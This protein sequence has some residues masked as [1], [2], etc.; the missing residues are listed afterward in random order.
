MK[1]VSLITTL[2]LASSIAIYAQ[3]SN[4]KEAKSIISSTN[5]D[6]NKAQTL[7]SAALNDPATKN[8]AETWNIAGKIQKRINETENEKMFLKKPCDTLAFYNSILE[9]YKYF[10]KCDE[11]AQIPNEKNKVKNKFRKDNAATM[12][13]NRGNIINGGVWNYRAKK[14]PEALIFFGTYIES[15]S[16][17]M[18]AE[19][20]I[21]KKDTLLGQVAYNAV[22]IAEMIGDHSSVIKY[23]PIAMTDKANGGNALRLL[24]ETYKSEK[25]SIKYIEAIKEGV[26]KY[27]DNQFFILNMIDYYTVHKETGKAMEFADQQLA[28]DPNNK[29][30]NYVKAYLLYNTKDYDKAIGIFQKVIKIDP[31]FAEPYS[32]LGSCYLQKAQEISTK[33]TTNINS[34]NYKKDQATIK[35]FCE[36]ARPNYEKARELKPND[37]DLWMQALY[38]IY[39]Q[40][41]MSSQFDEIERLMKGK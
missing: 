40:L 22:Y 25:D 16:Y 13:M 21:Q 14:Y 37:R 38:N 17:P 34:P 36:L 18:L 1:K 31:N 7:I 10:L 29:I 26:D 32:Y 27:P 23:A 2:F 9:M 28:K 24:A 4:V 39:Y 20:E 6:F 33:S 3:Q 41:N 8:D 30:F 35:S 12:F 5:S 19:Y 11:L 15:A